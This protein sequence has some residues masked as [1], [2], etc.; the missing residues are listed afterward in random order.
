MI[1]SYPTLICNHNDTVTLCRAI[2]RVLLNYI[3]N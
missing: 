1:I 3:C 2:F